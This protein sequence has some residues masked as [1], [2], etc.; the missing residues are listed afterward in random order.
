MLKAKDPEMVELG[1]TILTKY[2]DSFKKYKLFKQDHFPTTKSKDWRGGY[3][4]IASTVI[5]YPLQV[6]IHAIAKLNEL[7]RR[8]GNKNEQSGKDI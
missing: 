7:E 1:L 6:Q 8:L 3:T 4:T 5:P 2:L